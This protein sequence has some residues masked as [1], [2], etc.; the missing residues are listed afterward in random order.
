VLGGRA[1]PVVEIKPKLGAFY[2]YRSKY[3]QG[4]SAHLCPAP[5]PDRIAREARRLGLLAHHAL[6][7][8]GY[9]RTDMMLGKGGKLY[10]LET[11]TQPGMTPV[12]LLPDAA[13]A[14]GYSYLGLLEA[15]MRAA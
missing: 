8:R 4:G 9:S 14:A 10:V 12:S 3:A 7:C 5:L 11:N 1:L 2:D 15:M 6:G 13:R